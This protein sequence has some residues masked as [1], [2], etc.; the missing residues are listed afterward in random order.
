MS[1]GTSDLPVVVIGAGPVGLAAAARLAERGIA[2]QLLEAGDGVGAAVREWGHVRL[3]TSWRHNVDDVGRSLLEATGWVA[4]D[5]DVVPT[6]AELVERYLVPL[7][8]TPRITP[9]LRPGHKVTAISRVGVDRLRSRGRESAPF[10]IRANADGQAVEIQA[11]AVI[12]ATGTW[13]NPNVL[14]CSGLPARGETGARAGIGGAL[15]DVLGADRQAYEGRHTVVV[16]AGHS[17]ANTLLALVELA[18]LAV[19]ETRVSWV[20]RGESAALFYSDE[21]DQFPNRQEIGARLKE[22]VGAGRI[23]LINNFPVDAVRSLADGTIE[24]A[25]GAKRVSADRIVAATGYRP[26]HSMAAEV[27]LDIDP[28]MGAP[29]GLASLIDPNEHSCTAVPPHGVDE[30]AH[31]EPGFFVIGM[32][33]YGRAPS[34]LMATGYEQARSVVAAIAGDWV[35]A[36]EVRLNLSAASVCEPSSCAPEPVVV[37]LTVGPPSACGPCG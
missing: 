17:A 13:A 27:R 10:L 33:S 3:F 25:S 5:P 22:L 32:K 36:R 8:G 26:D 23:A 9:Y 31:P 35:G 7:A 21:A 28:I 19:P 24:L 12:D 37:S 11:R 15:P 6:G 16:G 2:F 29:R 30:L 20:I 1:S 4:P 34:F 14:G 18:D